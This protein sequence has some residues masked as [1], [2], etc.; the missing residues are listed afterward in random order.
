[1]YVYFT[2]IR[3]G[4]YVYIYI[5]RGPRV[6]YVTHMVTPPRFKL[7]REGPAVFLPPNQ[8][9]SEN[10]QRGLMGYKQNLCAHNTCI[11]YV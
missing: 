8:K 7:Y 1:M 5:T 10:H 2:L 9:D 11:I 6:I 3:V 4:M